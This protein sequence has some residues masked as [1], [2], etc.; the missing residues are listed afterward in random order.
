MASTKLCSEFLGFVGYF[1]RFIK[2]F[3]TIASP[4]NNVL[5]GHP[6]KIDKLSKKKDKRQPFIWGKEQQSAFEELKKQLMNP[7]ILIYADYNLPFKLHTDASLKGLQSVLY[8][9]QDGIIWV[10]AYTIRSLKPAERNYPAHT[11]W[12]NVLSSGRLQKGFTTTSI[13][14]ALLFEIITNNNPLTYVNTTAKLD[15]TGHRLMTAL[16][17][18][19]CKPSTEVGRTMQTQMAF[20]DYQL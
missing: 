8:Q 13:F 16:S 1:R 7:P 12:N 5:I 9:R 10:I 18:Y 3:A 17:N 15:A 2:G 6:L 19:N 11:N 14:I 20:H 4:F